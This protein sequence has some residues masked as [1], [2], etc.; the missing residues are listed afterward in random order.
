[1]FPVVFPKATARVAPAPGWD[2]PNPTQSSPTPITVLP[3]APQVWQEE[4]T[5]AEPPQKRPTLKGEDIFAAETKACDDIPPGILVPAVLSTSRNRKQVVGFFLVA[6]V[7][8]LLS[9][10][11]GTALMGRVYNTYSLAGDEYNGQITRGQLV[12]IYLLVFLGTLSIMMFANA[13]PSLV[14]FGWSRMK[15]A[16]TM[17]FMMLSFIVG[18]VLMVVYMWEPEK[19]YVRATAGLGTNDQGLIAVG[20]FFFVGFGFLALLIGGILWELFPTQVNSACARVMAHMPGWFVRMHCRRRVVAWMTFM[21]ILTLTVPTFSPGL[22]NL[23]GHTTPE[24]EYLANPDPNMLNWVWTDL[25]VVTFS[26]ECLG[27]YGFSLFILIATLLIRSNPRYRLAMHHRIWAPS[28]W[29]QR[30]KFFNWHPFPMG[31]SR[32]EV[33]VMIWMVLLMGFWVLNWLKLNP[34]LVNVV[35]KNAVIHKDLI[36]FARIVGHLASLV[37]SFVLLPVSRSGLWVDIFGV[38][39]E[40]ALKFHRLAG[41]F[42]YFLVLIHC[43]VN[44]IKWADDGTLANVVAYNELKITPYYIIYT[45]FSITLIEMAV[46]LMGVN[47]AMGV[48]M[49]RKLYKVFQYSHKYIGIVFY[50]VCLVHASNFWYTNL[51]GMVLWLCD[52]WVRG[53][54][55]SRLFVPTE[56][57]WHERNR[58][59]MIKLSSDSLP[60]YKPGQYFFINIPCLSLNEW[61]PFTASAVL[62]DGIV[63][64]IKNMQRKKGAGESWTSKLAELAL[65]DNPTMPV[66]RL[67][68]PFGH[69]SFENHE[70]I[71]LFAGGI[72]ITPMIAI[73]AGLRKRITEMDL[74]HKIAQQNGQ[75]QSTQPRHKN[76]R[77]T[78]MSRSISEFRLFET[79][80]SLFVRNTND[81]KPRKIHV[82][83]QDTICNMPE[84]I[85]EVD[86]SSPDDLGETELHAALRRSSVVDSSSISEATLED[87]GQGM[88]QTLS[89]T[90]DIQLHCTRRES[91]VS[92]TNPASPDY[93]SMFIRSGRCDVQQV[94][95]AFA[96]PGSTMAAVCGPPE[97]MMSVSR[98]AYQFNTAFH[99]EQF[100]F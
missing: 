17:L 31:I 81:G 78:W 71:L 37:F 85:T 52:K 33:L 79:I 51:P 64:Y 60:D 90:F 46:L 61:H 83:S 76:V 86:E 14:V 11:L 4:E 12:G 34:T 18:L 3:A 49:R 35:E 30:T 8:L 68:G 70:T 100:F 65:G 45:N 41:S 87:Q 21:L 42:G 15:L 44:Y 63:L 40:R 36:I 62:D 9:L 54:A 88:E 96:T 77:L 7:S 19:T 97:L 93:V 99:S 56:L 1:M 16:T 47:I 82:P 27:F 57:S 91:F 24:G 2:E 22:F 75:P 10:G 72:G 69:V 48:M 23:D 13:I 59:T 28:E 94:F 26:P 66:V 5:V 84:S 43:F 6:I 55:T 89:C 50:V 80:F 58:T 53:I 29:L 38:P 95:E 25:F 74:A 92:L 32:G 20:S 67:S 73:F 98:L 39:Y